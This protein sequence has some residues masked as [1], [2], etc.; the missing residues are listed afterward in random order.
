MS[1]ENPLRILQVIARLNIGGPAIYAILLCDQLA[2]KDYQTL[3]V[4]GKVSHSEGDMSYLVNPRKINFKL[5]SHLG[6]DISLLS[7][8]KALI[9]LIKIIKEFNPHIIHTHTAKAGTIG[10]LAGIVYNLFK[11]KESRIKL[12]HTFHGHVFSGYFSA[13]KTRIFIQI[14]RW[15]ARF[16]SRIIVLSPLQQADICRKY[17]IA[18]P[19]K[20]RIVPLGLDL[21]PFSEFKDKEAEQEIRSQ[22]LSPIADGMLTIGIIGRLTSIKN[23]HMFLQAIE[24]LKDQAGP[25]AFKSLIIGDG[26]LRQELSRFVV[27]RNLT[28][29][30]VFTGW[31]RNMAP[32]YKVLDIVVLTSRNEGTP[33]T[34]IEAMAA[35]KPV[36]TT[37]VG[38]VRDL[39]GPVLEKH[40]AGFS[41][42]RHGLLVPSGRADI[43]ARALRFMADH[44]ELAAEMG[45]YAQKFVLGHFSEDRLIR[46]IQ[47]I[48]QDLS[49]CYG[50][51]KI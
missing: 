11:A 14:E 20:T 51:N 15:L 32:F 25:V 45:R 10:R 6:R 3:L 36:V 16:T 43:F 8:L 28:E 21:K 34:L 4:Y 19:S 29:S 9:S 49:H 30:V 23:H 17:K 33:G 50:T 38:G 37:D 48:Y 12:V 39:M 41:V 35:R 2:K 24:Y 26:E 27:D 42:T 31:Q 1:S 40:A 13:S 22:Y 44:Q 46:D 7:D 47:T 18:R 5:I